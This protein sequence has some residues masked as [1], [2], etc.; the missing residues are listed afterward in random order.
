MALYHCAL[1]M[2]ALRLPQHKV[3]LYYSKHAKRAAQED[4]Y[5]D[6]TDILPRTLRVR[7]DQIIEVEVSPEGGKPGKVLVRLPK[8]RLDLC[9]VISPNL[10]NPWVWTVLTVWANTPD[11]SHRTLNADSYETV[12][13]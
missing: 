8:G 7:H 10:E 5:N 13:V 12:C 11:D 2:P 1:G 9:L 3:R 6:L 4:R